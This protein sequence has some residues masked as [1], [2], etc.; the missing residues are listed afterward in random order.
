MLSTLPLCSVSELIFSARREEGSAMGYTVFTADMSGRAFSRLV[1]VNL[2]EDP[3]TGPIYGMEYDLQ[4]NVSL[5][6]Y[7]V[8]MRAVSILLQILPSQTLLLQARSLSQGQ[9]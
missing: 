1:D 6:G 9:S 2:D 7:S 5:W 4:M 3:P 8:H